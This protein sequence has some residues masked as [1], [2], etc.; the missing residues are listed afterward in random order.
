MA[1]RIAVHL[2]GDSHLTKRHLVPRLLKEK[3]E[4]GQFGRYRHDPVLHAVSGQKL[5]EKYVAE[6]RDYIKKNDGRPMCHVLQIGS[7][8]LWD[9]PTEDTVEKILMFVRDLANRVLKSRTSALVITVPIPGDKPDAVKVFE[10]INKELKKEVEKTAKNKRL[11]IADFVG[12]CLPQGQDGARFDPE[13]WEDHRHLNR[14]GATKFVASITDVIRTLPMIVFGLKKTKK[15]K[16]SVKRR[17]VAVARDGYSKRGGKVQ[18]PTSGK[19]S[20]QPKPGNSGSK[21]HQQGPHT[22]RDLRHQLGRLEVAPRDLRRH[23]GRREVVPRRVVALP[24]DM[25]RPAYPAPSATV[26]SGAL[27]LMDRPLPAAYR[28][29]AEGCPQPMLPPPM[30]PMWQPLPPQWYVPPPP[31][32]M[33]TSAPA[34]TT[35]TTSTSERLQAERQR[36][37]HFRRLRQERE[38]EEEYRRLKAENDALEREFGGLHLRPSGSDGG[39]A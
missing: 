8:D 18:G 34:P 7:N 33:P 26:T 35:T 31:P 16:R 28:Y 30:A 4:A 21:S 1:S 24:P 23:L 12:R 13:L 25:R 11:S 5:T 36:A 14:K 22:M 20:S 29:D 32:P 3:L 2:W 15:E 38:E 19:G 27:A 10:S 39:N 17:T 9:T 37:E 6:M